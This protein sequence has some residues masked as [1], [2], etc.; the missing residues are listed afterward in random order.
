MIDRY[1]KL[2]QYLSSQGIEVQRV[3]VRPS[4]VSSEH[5]PDTIPV[6]WSPVAFIADKPIDLSLYPKTEAMSLASMAAVHALDLEPG[7][8]MLDVCA[9][10]GMK[11]L[12]ASKLIKGLELHVN[13]VQGDRIHR[14]ERIFGKHAVQRT[15]TKIDGRVIHD[16][17]VGQQFD[18]I[19]VDAPCSGEGVIMGCD[20]KLLSKWSQAKVRRL[21]QLQIKILKS[22]WPLLKPG[23]RLVYA[24]CTLNRTENER[25]LH[26]ALKRDVEVAESELSLDSLPALLD[27]QAWR[28]LP[29]KNSI[30]FFIAALVK[31]LGETQ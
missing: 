16:Y 3:D 24:T 26:K 15:T 21:Q 6:R 2:Q 4:F 12:Y 23:G 18:R 14:M 30:G 22:A 10:P 19:L 8:S 28:I 31:P 17:L 13:D 11:S 29:S 20:D 27:N 1:Q 25:V 9:A 5:V 7:M